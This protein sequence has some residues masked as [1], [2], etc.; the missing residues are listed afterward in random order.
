MPIQNGKLTDMALTEQKIKNAKPRKKQYKLS[1]SSGLHLLVHSNGGKYWQFK[2]RFAEKEKALS[3]GVFPMVKLKEA[4]QKRDDA[5]TQLRKGIDPAAKKR[6]EKLAAIYQ[7]RDSFIAVAE[8]WYEQ[9][10]GCWSTGYASDTWSRL[11]N[12]ALP[13]FGTR[14]ISEILPLEL[15]SV[16]QKIERRGKTDMSRRILQIVSAI[17]D[18]AIITG[19]A[20]YNITTGLHKALKKHRVKHNPTIT[21]K[22]VPEF[23]AEL[24]ALGSR[25]QNKLAFRLLL[26]TAVRTGEMRFSKWSDINFEK[27]EWRVRA[28]IMKMREEHVVPLSRQ[29]NRVLRK[30][31]QITGDSEWILPAVFK[32]KHPVISENLINDMIKRMGFKGR[33]VGHGFRALFSTVLNEQGFNPDAIERQ[34]AHAERNKIR[35]AYNRAE[36]LDERRE[37]MQWWADW[38]DEQKPKLLPAV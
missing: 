20:Q 6:E 16:V 37:L 28:E 29:T 2:Y 8:E 23:L 9:N 30:L 13:V 32:N 38:L 15:L 1:D 34:L 33:V 7:Q 24:E 11:Q 22:E 36:Y 10:K 27:R 21:A 14:P 3:L 18:Y 5:A 35:A 19:R 31:H 25:E 12:H 4:R 26:L 17:Y